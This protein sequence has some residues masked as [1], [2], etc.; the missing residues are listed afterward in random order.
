MAT[1]ITGITTDFDGD[2]R[3]ATTPDIGADEYTV[4]GGVP[5]QPT[6][7][8]PTDNA[9]EV[10]T[11]TDLAWNGIADTFHVYLWETASGTMLVD[12]QTTSNLFYDLPSLN[13]N[14]QY[15]WRIDATNTFGTTTGM[16]WS[17]TTT[18]PLSGI[19][20]IGGTTP[21]YTTIEEAINDLTL[22][23]V[24][25]GGVNFLIR[26]GV[27]NENDNM[28]ILDV[29]GVVTGQVLF[30][31]DTNATVE[32]NIDIVGNFSSAFKI[33]NSKY[34]KFSGI[35][36]GSTDTSLKNM[37]IN[38]NRNG[39]DDVFVFWVANGSHN[40]TLTNLNIN[41]NSPAT[42]TGW[43]PPVYVSTYQ[44]TS[45]N[46]G[47]DSFRLTDS[48]LV[49]GTTFGLFMDGEVGKEFT[50]FYIARNTIVDW[51]KFGIYLKSQIHDC[52]IESNEIYQT[53]DYARSSV[54]GISIHSTITGTKFHHNY[55]HNLK[56]SE[57]S[58]P[59]G[60]YMYGGASDNLIYNNIVH[61]TPR[62]TA[63]SSKCMGVS[64]SGEGTGNEIYYNTFY[65][66]GV[67]TRGTNSYCL[68]ID[69]EL[70]GLLVKNNLL[71][72]ERT[73]GDGTNGHYAIS[74]ELATSCSESDYNFISVNS[75]DPSDNRYV[76]EVNELPYNT[77][78]DLQAAP[79]YAPRDVNSITGN[80]DLNMTDFH[81][82][83]TSNCIGA[84]TTIVG[85]TT[86]FDWEIRDTSTPD[87][88]ADEF[89][90]VSSV[91]EVSLATHLKNYPNPFYQFTTISF[92][93]YQ[94]APVLLEIY[95]TNGQH[96]QTLINKTM[97]AGNHKIVWNIT[98][99]EVAK[100]NSGLYFYKFTSLNKS[101][102]GK[103]L[104]LK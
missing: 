31:P 79:N 42:D 44:V 81:L 46:V 58:G 67:D 87:I 70:A 32:V 41:S 100:T 24:G 45:P 8:N 63:N 54:Y 17:F 90:A 75:T 103:M 43:S 10:L 9:T 104:V 11:S 68:D 30:Q 88:G 71:L 50:N 34:I 101:T 62:E 89:D 57:L 97:P 82:T 25:S 78:A 73:G 23:G 2:T 61:L 59:T 99:N 95:N 74:L 13:G 66:G 19:K 48:N 47:I 1:P 35:P 28:T 16:E 6:D 3:H 60:I 22:K 5:A 38:G 85:I 51:Q 39:T 4:V 72:N 52:E 86:D 102:V 77:L 27:Y 91:D 15:S 83:A 56:H 53:F 29:P 80:P 64:W 12:N 93:T 96:I 55:I 94:N 21:D 84:A 40:C 98:D 36:Y 18:S 14:T 33:H 76:A 20:T 65:M 37:T 69:N 7:P 26:D 49:G 92:T